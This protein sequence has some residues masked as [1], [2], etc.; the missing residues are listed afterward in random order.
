EPTVGEALLSRVL[1]RFA[2]HPLT[3]SPSQ[4]LSK[5]RSTFPLPF[6]GF[7]VCSERA[8]PNETAVALAF[9]VRSFYNRARGS[10]LPSRPLLFVREAGP[11]TSRKII[12]VHGN[13]EFSPPAGSQ[14]GSPAGTGAVESGRGAGQHAGPH[15]HSPHLH[16]DD[17]SPLRR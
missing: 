14:P 17:R 4:T 12:A 15:R 11:P 16:A 5:N 7:F 6:P 1:K 9:L 2:C 8:A 3:P 10:V 13:H